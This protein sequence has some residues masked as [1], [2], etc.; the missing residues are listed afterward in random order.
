ME[1]A[2]VRQW[3]RTT[4]GGQVV[5]ASSTS[6]DMGRLWVLS[7]DLATCGECKGL[8]SINGTAVDVVEDGKATVV[9]WD[10][11]LCPCGKN[12]VLASQDCTSFIEDVNPGYDVVGNSMLQT[13]NNK[14]DNKNE[15]YFRKIKVVDS[16]TKVTLVNHEW[17]AYVEGGQVQRGRVDDDGFAVVKTDSE[18]SFKLHVF[19]SSPKKNLRPE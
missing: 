3:D 6:S 15:M 11:V 8:F 13:Q 9:H 5:S 12:H 14:L 18:R 10:L 17:V 7:G 19:F 4:T 2:I 16:S 1:K